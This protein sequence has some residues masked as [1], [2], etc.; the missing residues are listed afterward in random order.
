VCNRSYNALLELVQDRLLPDAE[1]FLSFLQ[2]I[3]RMLPSGAFSDSC[4]VLCTSCPIYVTHRFTRNHSWLG[5]HVSEIAIKSQGTDSPSIPLT[6]NHRHSS[7]EKYAWECSLDRG[8]LFPS[9]IVLIDRMEGDHRTMVAYSFVLS[10]FCSRQSLS[11][12]QFCRQVD[13]IHGSQFRSNRQDRFR[14]F[15]HVLTRIYFRGSFLTYRLM[16]T[17]LFNCESGNFPR[18][19]RTVFFDARFHRFWRQ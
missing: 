6:V 9:M 7:M 14:R 1:R 4:Q 15:A 11:R 5:D 8:Y 18:I 16:I 17:E 3:V 10:A 13:L 12:K 19:P 2:E